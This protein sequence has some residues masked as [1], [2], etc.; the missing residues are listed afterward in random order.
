MLKKTLR[1]NVIPDAYTEET[2]KWTSSSTS[3]ETSEDSEVPP[4]G[5]SVLSDTE[6]IQ[7]AYRAENGQ[8][9]KYLFTEWWPAPGLMSR[10]D[11][12]R[13]AILALFIHLR[14]WARHD[15][16]QVIRLFEENQIFHNSGEMKGDYRELLE[17]AGELLGTES[18]DPEYRATDE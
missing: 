7:K 3:T 16:G 11:S 2:E 18:Y 14:W 12:E 15:L 13:G 17:A 9:F 10:Y 6:L 5:V 8:K 1:K 4:L